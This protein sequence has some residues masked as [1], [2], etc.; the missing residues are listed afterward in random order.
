MS[1]FAGRWIGLAIVFGWFFFGGIGHFVKTDFFVSIVPPYISHPLAVVYISGVCE[2]LGAFGVL[3]PATR[4]LA[5]LGLILLTLCVTPANVHM[6]LHPQQFP[7]LPEWAYSV[8]L[9]VQVL[10]LACIW[11]STQ[12]KKSA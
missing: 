10:L 6:W 1:Q 11:W 5:G 3:L 12:Q 2:L 4:R 8:R 7:D 9:V